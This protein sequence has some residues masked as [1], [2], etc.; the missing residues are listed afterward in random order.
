M[1]F[2]LIGLASLLVFSAFFSS[3]EI[4][5]IL[6]NK[7][8]IEIR[9][10]NN[11]LSAKNS[12]YF[13]KNPQKYFSTILI[14]NNIVNI[15]FSSFLTIFLT[16]YFSLTEITILVMSTAFIFLLGELIPKL[17]ATENPDK[18][19]EFTS[20][21]I[22]IISFILYPFVYLSV[23]FSAFITGDK[24]NER[25][26]NYIL[27]RED[28]N[29]LIEES[30]EAGNFDEQNTDIIKNVLKM[31][32]QRVVE[33]MT[34]RTAIVGIDISSTIE[35][36]LDLFIESGYS[37]LVVYEESADHIRGI[38]LA[39][40]MFKK[41][42]SIESILREIPYIPESKRSMDTLD[43]LLAK[44]ISMAIVVDEFGGTAGLITIEDVIEEMV[45]EINDEFDDNEIVNKKIDDSTFLF[46]GKA[47]ID[48]INE[49]F[50]IGI[51]DGEYETIA[52]FITSQIGRIPVK[53]EKIMI[54][55]FQ[56]E[57]LFA[58]KVKIEL[59]KVKIRA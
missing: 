53:G 9:S 55:K 13:F 39:Y 42:E 7:L 10:R 4:G 52:G 25:G 46:S 51:P 19:Y 3:S 5:Y 56:I 11:K 54:G 29:T 44:N 33:V 48:F 12:Y 45:G 8:K 2:Q 20:T 43:E 26:I 6:S 27:Y 30:N 31:S 28:I 34:P 37:K 22:R 32:N 16:Y 35:E 57:I 40:D 14:S 18:F 17:I 36:A 50:G 21:P 24:I 38:I 58:D 59:I 49:E 1:I 41:P 23:K 47:E 15:T